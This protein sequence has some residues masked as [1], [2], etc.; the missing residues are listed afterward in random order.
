MTNIVDPN[1]RCCHAGI[2]CTC[3]PVHERMGAQLT[4][5]TEVAHFPTGSAFFNP[6]ARRT[7]ADIA[8]LAERRA[9]QE[10][11]L[12]MSHVLDVDAALA[13]YQLAK[14]D[15]VQARRALLLLASTCL[16]AAGGLPDA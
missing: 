4:T 14:G 2:P 3:C 16:A 10:H 6:G 8:E 12:T 11:R 5:R 15:A 7:Y 9:R 13:L 1:C